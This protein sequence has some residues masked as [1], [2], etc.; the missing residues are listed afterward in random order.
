MKLGKELTA[1]RNEMESRGYIYMTNKV[2]FNMHQVLA[3]ALYGEGTYVTFTA[4]LVDL[5]IEINLI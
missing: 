2:K 4:S 1:E 3:D 5:N